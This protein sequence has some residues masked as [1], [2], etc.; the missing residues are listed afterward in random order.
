MKNCLTYSSHFHLCFLQQTLSSSLH[1]AI[2]LRFDLELFHH[3][4]LRGNDSCNCSTCDLFSERALAHL[5]HLWLESSS[6]LHGISEVAL[7]YRH[8][9]PKASSRWSWSD[10]CRWRT[11]LYLRFLNLQ[12]CRWRPR[13]RSSCDCLLVRG[14][15]RIAYITPI[16]GTRASRRPEYL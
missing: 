14:C 10:R 11:H 5:D 4:Q 7:F 9:D 13:Q 16:G 2:S 1:L 3:L 15:L 6:I 12:R 8:L